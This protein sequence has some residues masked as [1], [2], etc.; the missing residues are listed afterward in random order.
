[1]LV[2]YV[3]SHRIKD[4]ALGTSLLHSLFKRLES[5]E[6]AGVLSISSLEATLP[7]IAQPIPEGNLAW[8]NQMIQESSANSEKD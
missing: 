7:A 2:S 3:V 8:L 6:H 4:G 1:M 5:H